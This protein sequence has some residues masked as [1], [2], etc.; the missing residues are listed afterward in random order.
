MFNN[1]SYIDDNQ[2]ESNTDSKISGLT[3]KMSVN[4]NLISLKEYMEKRK[5]PY[6][7][8]SLT[9]QWWDNQANINFKVS[10]D[11]YDEFIGIYA[12]EIKNNKNKKILHVMEQ[13]KE[14]GPLCLDFDLKQIS[15]ERTINVD[16]ISQIISVVNNII[17]KYY[18][19]KN[20]STL[21]S[22]VF[23]KK[24]PFLD[25]KKSLYSDGFHIEYPNLILNSH[26]R[27][28]IYNESRKEIIRQDLFS[29]VYST[30]ANVK[31]TLN[32][33]DSDE[34]ENNSESDSE[35]DSELTN[36]YSKLSD[37]EKEKI[38]DE[39]FDPC[40]IVKNK[41]FMYGSGKN[42]NGDINIYQLAYIFDYDVD[43][44]NDIPRTKELIKILSIRKPTN[45]E[46]LIKPKISD[47]YKS[48]IDEVR[49]KY[50]KKTLDL[51]KLFKPP[52]LGSQ[53]SN[54]KHVQNQEDNLEQIESG[55]N[56]KITKL[57]GQYHPGNKN[58]DDIAQARR[59]V[60]MLSPSRAVPHDEWISVG[61]ALYNVSPKL[62][63]EFIEF[64]KQCKKKFD[65]QGCIKVW[66][67]C[68]RR[69]EDSGYSLPS[70]VRW[71]KEDNIEGYKKMLREKINVMLDKG[72]IKTDFDVACILKEM[73][74][75]EYK[76]SSISKGIWWQFDNHRWNRIECA[77][78]FSIKMSTDIAQEFAK[79][80]FDIM[81]I[82]V[83]ETGQK[84][85]T[86]QRRCKDIHTLIF[87]L[88]KT[89]FKDRI[90]KECGTLFY[91]KDFE[92]KLDQN[93]YL[94]GFTNGVYDLRNKN[95]TADSE[96]KIKYEPYGFRKGS[97]DDFIGKT[98]GYEY[99]EKL[100][101]NDPKIK[102]IE[103]FIESIQPDEGMRK[104]LMAYCASFL[105]GSNKDQKFMIWTGSG[106]NG[107]AVACLKTSEYRKIYLGLN[108]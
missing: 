35:N 72:D 75:Y 55:S 49:L 44:I 34:P 21:D 53:N 102:D 92:S 57:M 95:T 66:E 11:E 88:K 31:K 38:N 33:M 4:D 12:R 43:E 70:L 52:N 23:M 8:K 74:K 9:H 32:D 17:V 6:G 24:E 103:K 54:Q 40:V 61:W 86:L 106:M 5:T 73:Y 78:T 65:E 45:D 93:N 77:H 58:V 51:N 29:H 108:V 10:D 15:P 101:E 25:R 68:S 59:L 94:I 7:D 36:N 47:D 79:L 96:G 63:P 50:M 42:I 27:F 39:I 105:E 100:N 22:Y 60:K 3:E 19:I 91:E 1:M 30:L 98:V 64:S 28:L 99:N 90:I 26:D 62:Y 69:Y 87:N 20:N 56:E 46:N 85:D 13:P 67:D 80:H 37:K 89:A 41:W 2:Y 18:T 14:I 83:Q 82:A 104:Y 107:K 16:D 84:A 71:V 97:P 48:K 81:Q 76:C